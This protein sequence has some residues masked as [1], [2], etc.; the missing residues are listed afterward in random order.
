MQKMIWQLAAAIGL[1]R[2][3]DLLRDNVRL[4]CLSMG[5]LLMAAI[6][7]YVAPPHLAPSLQSGLALLAFP[8]VG[9]IMFATFRLELMYTIQKVEN[10][11]YFF[12]LESVGSN[13]MCTS[14]FGV[15][16]FSLAVY[17]FSLIEHIL[18]WLVFIYFFKWQ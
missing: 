9:V 17:V 12:L 11:R 10:F 15:L 2:L 18:C 7:P 13:W 1:T 14:F 3:A 16:G 5:M 4:C 8:L 6:C